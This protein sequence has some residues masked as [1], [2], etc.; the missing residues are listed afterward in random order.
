MR[1]RVWTYHVL[2]SFKRPCNR[3]NINEDFYDSGSIWI[4]STL[5]WNIESEIWISFEDI[6]FFLCRN[7]YEWKPQVSKMKLYRSRNYIL[8][9]APWYK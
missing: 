2:R 4:K 1:T 3:T 7:I 8:I 5:S 6:D 9:L